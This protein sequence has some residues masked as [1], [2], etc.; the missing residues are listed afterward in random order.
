VG[1][2]VNTGDLVGGDKD[3]SGNLGA[4]EWRRYWRLGEWGVKTTVETQQVGSK[5]DSGNLGAG[6][7]RRHWRLSGWG[8]K[9][10]G[11]T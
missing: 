6:E 1:S 5:D 7:W 11:E 2:K 10:T 3:D 4:G 9:T 8:V